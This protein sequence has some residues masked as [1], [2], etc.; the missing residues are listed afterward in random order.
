MT[1]KSSTSV[2]SQDHPLSHDGGME[3]PQ[4]KEEPVPS[5]LILG[6]GAV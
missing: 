5:M 1:R 4:K 3:N 6:K 2:K